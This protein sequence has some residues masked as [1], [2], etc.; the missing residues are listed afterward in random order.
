T[1]GRRKG[2]PG[3][4]ERCAGNYSKTSELKH[5][6]GFLSFT[7]NDSTREATKDGRCK[8]REVK[9]DGSKQHNRVAETEWLSTEARHHQPSATDRDKNKASGDYYLCED[10][11]LWL[12]QPHKSMQSYQ[13]CNY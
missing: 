3:S 9:M 5:R 2:N 4:H 7:R 10:P 8:S 11:V 13:P 12:K 6:A 1:Q